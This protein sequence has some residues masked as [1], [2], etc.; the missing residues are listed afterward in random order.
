[1][2]TKF[3]DL[4]EEKRHPHMRRRPYKDLQQVQQSKLPMKTPALGCGKPG[5]KKTEDTRGPSR[6]SKNS[7][8]RTQEYQ[9]SEFM[10]GIPE[11]Q[12]RPKKKS[13]LTRG[14]QQLTHFNRVSEPTIE[15]KKEK[16]S[17]RLRHAGTL[18]VR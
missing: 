16:K 14:N 5:T 10:E 8:T 13:S 11:K 3:S 1:M 2:I 17:N 9:K 7:T 18:T 15:K 12:N 6:M 4:N